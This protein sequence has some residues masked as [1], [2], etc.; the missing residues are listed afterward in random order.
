[1]G[2]GDAVGIVLQLLIQ[3]DDMQ[4]VQ[5][6]TLVLVKPLDLHVENGVGVQGHTLSFPGVVG[7]L[8]LV[9]PLDLVQT[10]E[11]SRIIRIGIQLFQRLRMEQVVV[12]TGQIPYQA[13]QT[14]ICLLYTSRCV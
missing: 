10:L 9:L 8:H 14:R 13:V 11:D 2:P 12:S 3:G 7:K 1:M 5:Q 6:L 4:Y